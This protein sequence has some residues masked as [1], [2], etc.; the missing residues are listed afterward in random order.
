[1]AGDYRRKYVKKYRTY[2][3]TLDDEYVKPKKSGKRPS[4]G[5][6]WIRKQ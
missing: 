1:M 3:P 6:K 5:G 2:K 4:D